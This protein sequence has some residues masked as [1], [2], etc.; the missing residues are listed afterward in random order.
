MNLF[1][2]MDSLRFCLALGPLAIYLL[3][4]G[5]IN[6]SRRSWVITG[7]RDLAALGVGLSGFIIV[8]PIELLMPQHAANQFGPYIWLMLLVMYSLALSLA[9]LMSR[10]RL[11]IYNVSASELRAILAEVIES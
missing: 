7:S 6:L 10:P 4:I 1:A 3:L 11:T 8:G 2:P 5:G 9:V